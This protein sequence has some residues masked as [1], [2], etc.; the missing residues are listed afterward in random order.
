MSRLET[1]LPVFRMDPPEYREPR[2]ITAAEAEDCSLPHGTVLLLR[3]SEDRTLDELLSSYEALHLRI[4]GAPVVLWTD[5]L[6]RGATIEIVQRLARA[7]FDPPLLDLE[8]TLHHLRQELT[9]VARFPRAFVS[10]A[11]AR[12]LVRDYRLEKDLHSLVTGAREHR[13]LSAFAGSDR[14][15]KSLERDFD[16]GCL[17]R[18]SAFFHV[19]RLLWFC[20]DLQRTPDVRIADVAVEFGYASDKVGFEDPV[21]GAR[22]PADRDPASSRLAVVGTEWAPA[23]G[24]L[25]GFA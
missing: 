22:V 15:L 5:L 13:T 25:P 14:V 16:R 8:A 20:L 4:A 24:G 12:G 11:E 3:G 9:N 10:W 2:R 7:G 21:R 18:P 17:K 1:Q 23:A 19:V 6:P